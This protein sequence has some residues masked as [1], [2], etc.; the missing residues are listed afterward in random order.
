MSCLNNARAKLSK[1]ASRSAGVGCIDSGSLCFSV[2]SVTTGSHALRL[3]SNHR[4]QDAHR[5]A[6]VRWLKQQLNGRERALV[7][8]WAQLRK[9]VEALAC[10]IMAHATRPDPTEWQVVLAHV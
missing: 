4:L 5:S 1:R 10:V 9:G 8:D 3:Q 6:S 7:K 2:E